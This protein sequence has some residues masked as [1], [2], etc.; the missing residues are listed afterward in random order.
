MKN[1]LLLITLLIA[2]GNTQAQDAFEL[3]PEW[4]KN[5]IW[6]QIMVER[7][8]NADTANDPK[9]DNMLAP[10]EGAIAPTGWHITPWAQNWFKADDWMV[11]NKLDLK[12]A[13]G[14][15]RYGGDLQ[16]VIDKL[17][18]L[19]DLGITAI[20]LNPVNDAPSLHKYD[21]R[22][23]H[24]VDVNF[25]PT[26]DTDTKLMATENPADASTWVWTNADKLFLK[27]ISEAHNRNIK[28]IVDF[29][30]NHTGTEFWAWKD[31]I[32]KQEKSA[33]K[34]WYYIQTFDNPATTQNDMIY[35]GWANL[36]GLPELRKS[37]IVSARKS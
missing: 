36:K 24:H 7:F 10:N 4:S 11:N 2:F 12:H 18:Y 16:G 37:N 13:F 27:L 22:S 26:P 14:Y 23:Y 5:A 19:V 1:L 34:D 17:D 3:P 33:Y 25:G 29:S 20:Y 28:V 35:K 21:A 32:E 8:H 15:R 30:W 9:P 6:Y 31:I